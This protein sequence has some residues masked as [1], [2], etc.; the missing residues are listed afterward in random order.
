LTTSAEVI[1]TK[2][3][4]AFGYYVPEN[5]LV[6]LRREDLRLGSEA[7]KAGFTQ[8]QLDELLEMAPRRPDG[9]YQALASRK[10]EGEP[11]GQFKFWGT[12]PDDPND[13]FRHENRRELRGLRLF[14]AWLNHV[15]IDTINT[16]DVFIGKKDRGHVRHYLIDFGTTLGSGAFEP[17]RP[18]V[19]HE[20]PTAWGPILKSV[21]SLGLW[22]RE[23]QKID[24]PD[25]PQVGNFEAAHFRPERWIPDY[26][27]P[28]FDRTRLNDA[29]WAT[30]IIAEFSDEMIRQIVRVGSISDRKAED[31]LIAT[32]LERRDRIL[33]YYL[34]RINPVDRF[35]VLAA[36]TELRLAFRNLAARTGLP[37]P[38]SYEYTWYAFDN[39]S[40][41]LRRVA[42]P[43][44]VRQESIPF[45]NGTRYSHLVA[46]FRT[47]SRNPEWAKPVLVYL[48]REQAGYRIIGI[49]REEES[50]QLDLPK[51]RQLAERQQGSATAGE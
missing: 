19:G 30:S 29:F 24:Y 15:D 11:I 4:H 20:Y 50:R 41:E 38:D 5:Y 6:F 16:M 32:L 42:A 12:R 45:P 35:Q 10:I 3:F 43:Q 25:Y 34:S 1:S 47:I 46:E 9:K 26:R 48:Q 28:A 37:L 49:D 33:R 7:A 23:W 14:C 31:Y 8:K 51:R 36:R 17:Q 18:R 22:E 2:F 44:N 27:N 39:Q 13:I 21:F 40:D